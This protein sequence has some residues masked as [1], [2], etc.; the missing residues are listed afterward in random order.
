MRLYGQKRLYVQSQR[1]THQEEF[2][3]SHAIREGFDKSHFDA[4]LRARDW[5]DSRIA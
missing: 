2:A 3:P 4:V 5:D 1:G